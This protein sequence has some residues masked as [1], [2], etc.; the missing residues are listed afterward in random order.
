MRISKINRFALLG[1][2][3]IVTLGIFTLWMNHGDHHQVASVSRKSSKLK[4]SHL[5]LLQDLALQ[6]KLFVENKINFYDEVVE[7]LIETEPLETLLPRPMPHKGHNFQ[8]AFVKN[9]AVR[10]KT[11]PMVNTLP[12][13]PK[14]AL[15]IMSSLRTGSSF[16]GQFFN[17]HPDVFYM[18]EPLFLFHDS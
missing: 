16:T 18:F 4:R 11:L 15:I 14:P 3:A 5:T 12:P 10:K 2:L 6:E 13:I 17:Q 7:K 1:F 8:F 9:P